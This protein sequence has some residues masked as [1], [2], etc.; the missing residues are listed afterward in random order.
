[1][2]SFS[3]FAGF[4]GFV[5]CSDRAESLVPDR[6]NP[7]LFAATPSSPALVSQTKTVRGITADQLKDQ[8]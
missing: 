6:I 1:M 8:P 5:F 4:E 7:T 2:P 3:D